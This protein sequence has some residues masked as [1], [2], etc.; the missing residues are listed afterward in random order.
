MAMASAD[1]YRIGQIVR[2]F[3]VT[4]RAVRYYEECGLV[5]PA[6]SG[7]D[8]VFSPADYDRLRFIIE[9]RRAG[10]GVIDIHELLDLYD[11]K[12][13]GRRQLERKVQLMR[14]QLEALDAQRHALEAGIELSLSALD[15]LDR[16]TSKAA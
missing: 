10:L 1:R 13:G 11:P 7:T 14:T 3:G 15:N 12:D 9:A 8:R 6:R 2:A 5:R 4:P 16:P